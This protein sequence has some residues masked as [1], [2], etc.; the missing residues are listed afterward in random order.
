MRQILRAGIAA[1]TLS[2][3]LSFTAIAG[4]PKDLPYPS[5]NLTADQI[6]EQVYFVNHF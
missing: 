4:V 3:T 6:M 1:F 2:T 5:G